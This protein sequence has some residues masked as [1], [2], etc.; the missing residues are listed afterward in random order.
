MNPIT[1]NLHT[2]IKLHK[3]KT[4]IRPM[5]N[6]KNAPA[7]QQA[8][9]LTKTLHNY[10]QL[11]YKYNVQNSIHLMTDLQ[12]IQLNKDTRLCSFDIENMYTNIPEVSIINIIL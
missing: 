5:I 7:Y 6:W 1:P 4:P 11:P 3:Q 10:L 12:A 2:K 9:Q 8:K